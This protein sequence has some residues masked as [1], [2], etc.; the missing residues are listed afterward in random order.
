MRARG[1]WTWESDRS[2]GEVI[3]LLRSASSGTRTSIGGSGLRAL[4]LPGRR[5]VLWGSGG[6]SPFGRSRFVGRVL[7][8][9]S[10]SSIVGTIRTPVVLSIL[11]RVGGARPGATIGRDLEVI[12]SAR[13][14][15]APPTEGPACPR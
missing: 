9:S 10:G 11:R 7:E 13:L 3:D 2:P 15:E 4:V 5:V 6:W 12:C 8:R 1:T 14:V